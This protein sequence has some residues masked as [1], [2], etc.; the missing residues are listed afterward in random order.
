[1]AIDGDSEQPPTNVG[2]L[3]A[4]L[5]DL[6]GAET[7][8]IERPQGGGKEALF[9]ILPEG[10]HVQSLKPLLD[11]YLE[12][13]ERRRGTVRAFDVGSFTGLVSRFASLASVVFADPN[14]GKPKFTAVFDYH[15]KSDKATD[16]DWL[17]HRAVYEPALSEEWKAW[18]ANNGKLHSVG[19][20]AAFIEDR[21]SDVVVPDENDERIREFS[22]L[23]QGRFAMP[24]DLLELSRGLSVN[25]E[26]AVRNAVTLNTGE[27]SVVYE[28]QHRDGGGHPVKIANLFQIVVPV[29]YAGQAYRVAARLRYRVVNGKI[30]WMYQLVRP[31]LVFDDAFAGIAN[32]VRKETG[33]PVFLG[34]PEA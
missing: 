13:P 34:A 12:R 6:Y 25:V 26:T 4:E 1:M 29:F 15:A 7:V 23:V 5:Q 10:K 16:A 3:A 32:T 18:L 9:A 24:S 19:D 31:D 11:E 20:F 33:Q 28:E 17:Q 2:A 21:I 14:A 27:I 30:N 8:L 22:Q